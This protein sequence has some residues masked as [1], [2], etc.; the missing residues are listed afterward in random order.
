MTSDPSPPSFVTIEPIK[1][2]YALRPAAGKEVPALA[3]LWHD[4]W[5]DG[6]LGHVPIALEAHRT[7]DGFRRRMADRVDLTTVAEGDGGPIG[8]V[9]VRDDEVEQLHVAAAARG[10]G[11]AVA[12]LDHAERQIARRHEQAWLAVVAGNERAR[13]FYRRQGWRDRGEVAYPADDLTVLAHR[14]ERTLPCPDR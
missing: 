5:R 9:T 12:L 7:L 14:Y 4:A 8:F 2:S 3:T 6:H 13:S 10:T 11:V 1:T